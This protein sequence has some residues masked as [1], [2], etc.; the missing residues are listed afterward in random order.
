MVRVSETRL[1]EITTVAKDGSATVNGS[2]ARFTN[3]ADPVDDQDLATKAY[4]DSLSG[5]GSLPGE[6]VD[7]YERMYGIAGDYSTSETD[8][9]TIGAFVLNTFDH[10]DY[11]DYIFQ[12]ILETDDN[13]ISADVR[14]YNATTLEAVTDTDLS[15][16]SEDPELVQSPFT[17]SS[18]ENI[19]L[20]QLK[21]GTVDGYAYC[22]NAV[23]LASVIRADCTGT[24]TLFDEVEGEVTTTSSLPSAN[25]ASVSMTSNDVVKNIHAIITA[26]DLVNG[27]SGIWILTGGFKRIDDTISQLGSSAILNSESDNADFDVDFEIG[28]GAINIVVTGDE[29]NN[30]RWKT[31]VHIVS[32]DAPLVPVIS[33]PEAEG[34]F[35]ASEGITY[36][37]GT[38]GI[39]VLDNRSG[40]S[41]V[42][43]FNMYDDGYARPEIVTDTDL[44]APAIKQWANP[45]GYSTALRGVVYAGTY[46]TRTTFS[47]HTVIK[48]T[49]SP[50]HGNIILGGGAAWEIELARDQDSNPA[51]YVSGTELSNTVIPLNQWCSFVVE[52]DGTSVQA[53]INGQLTDSVTLSVSNVFGSWCELSSLDV[54]DAVVSYNFAEFEVYFQTVEGTVLNQIWARDQLRYPA[55]F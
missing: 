8:Y 51:V 18:G 49:Y 39:Q 46:M 24:A 11:S 42:F 40:A 2:N 19:Y 41:P 47:I 33:M 28:S 55:V 27:D 13:S 7:G 53:W 34:I 45:D 31:T 48:R 15:S 36:F 16:Y 17:P 20:V 6:G 22:K 52:I 29:I 9:Q 35:L 37:S 5:G 14:L 4:V 38:S 12:A 30:V 3:A 25:V 21:T 23:V 26:K 32:E 44:T 43:L 50:S 10:P 1:K 54:V